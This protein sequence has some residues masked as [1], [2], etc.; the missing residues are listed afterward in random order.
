MCVS[1]MD[2]DYLLQLK[3]PIF[4]KPA[5]YI[6]HQECPGN[7]A[8]RCG[9][10]GAGLYDNNDPNWHPHDT[11]GLLSRMERYKNTWLP[12]TGRLHAALIIK[13]ALVATTGD[14]VGTNA[15]GS[16]FN[17]T[18]GNK[19]LVEEMEKIFHSELDKQGLRWKQD[20]KNELFVPN[21]P[22][23]GVQQLIDV[24]RTIQGLDLYLFNNQTFFKDST[25]T[26]GVAHSLPPQV[27]GTRQA[28]LRAVRAPTMNIQMNKDYFQQLRSAN[29]SVFQQILNLASQVANT[30]PPPQ[31]PPPLLPPQPSPQLFQPS[32]QTKIAHKNAGMPVPPVQP[33]PQ[34]PQ[35]KKK[36]SATQKRKAHSWLPSGYVYF[37]HQ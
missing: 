4:N 9:L 14:K 28:P 22:Q 33:P 36:V 32:Q 34:L 2:L 29:P 16:Q 1:K 26:G 20:K 5:L 19:T 6:V 24:L 30:P 12:I 13:E 3:P 37:N 8:Y 11:Y 10:S 27:V 18:R 15:S 23:K 25:Y 7:S 17:Q 35:Q 21:D 31:P